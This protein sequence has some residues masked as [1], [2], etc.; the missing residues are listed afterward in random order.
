MWLGSLS[1]LPPVMMLLCALISA[2]QLV[3]AFNNLIK[4][5][6]NMKKERLFDK[7]VWNLRWL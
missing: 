7:G 1:L 4:K 6:V 3:Q 5:G 2:F